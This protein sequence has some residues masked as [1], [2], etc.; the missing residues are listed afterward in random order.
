MRC[1]FCAKGDTR[2]VD[3]RETD[4]AEVT[5]RRREC[6]SCNK[7][8]TTYE[9]AEGGELVVIKK[10]QSRQQ[11]DRSKLLGGLRKACE[12]RPISLEQLQEICV[13]IESRL[14]HKHGPEVSS[15][16]IGQMVVDRLRMLDNVAYIRFASVYREFQD[17]ESFQREVNQLLKLKKE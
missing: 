3:T 8:F 10:D 14:R 13:D 15:S 2:V 5:R 6:S 9:R 17:V 11:F 4:E 1:L 12:K 7:R 16:L